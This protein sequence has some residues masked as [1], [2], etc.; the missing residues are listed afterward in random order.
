MTGDRLIP[1]ETVDELSA[2][3]AVGALDPAE[4]R[5]VSE[6]LATCRAPHAEARA[7][8]DS[9]A[10]LAAS[11]EPIEPSAGLR[12]RVMATVAAT[13]Q[14]HRAT[15]SAAPVTSIGSAGRPWWTTSRIPM[16]IAAV[17]LAAA[18]GLGAWAAQLSGQ[19]GDRDAALRAVAADDAIHA[20]SG[21][22]GK[23]WVI[24]T[25]GRAMFMADDLAALPAGHL[26]ELWLISAD[27]VP[28]AVG[29]LEDPRGV[30]LVT[31]DSP[32][33]EA[34]AFAVTVESARVEAPTSDP[35]IVA[36]L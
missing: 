11:L 29:T 9:A 5:A 18:V 14:E 3:Y 21:S 16:A 15:L 8:L 28:E 22:A 6:H 33:E 13:A 17:A 27:G 20:A 31:L 34:R 35:V 2:A 26:Y 1:C 30:A 25:D 24:E 32:L 36:P 23:G 12:S 10:L 4:E 19:L 7:A